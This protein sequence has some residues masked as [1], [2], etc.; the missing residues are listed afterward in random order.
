MT[1]HDDPATPADRDDATRA[2]VAQLLQGFDLA[3]GDGSARALHLA[4]DLFS[5]A[6]LLDPSRPEPFLGLGLCCMNLGHESRGLDFFDQCLARGFGR[7]DFAKL[8]YERDDAHGGT[9][10]FEIALDNVLCWRAVCHL[11]LDDPDAAA[12]ELAR[13]SEDPA[14]ELRGGLCALRGLVYFAAAD[15]FAAER[16]L[17][18]ALAWD[19]DEPD[20]HV[21]RAL[22]HERRG[23]LTA[24]LRAFGRAIRLDPTEPDR[25]VAHARVLL[26]A[27]QGRKAAQE[28]SAAQRLLEQELPQSERLARI[29]A[30]RNAPGPLS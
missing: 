14:V 3:I 17:G 20:A 15:L 28:L 6:A 9:R 29:A 13:V 27:G 4:L 8:S 22:L 19:R 1:D 30:L 10:T 24:S 12:R 25:R 7:G 18:Q 11:G 26:A 16:E 2:C 23:E 5:R 21:L